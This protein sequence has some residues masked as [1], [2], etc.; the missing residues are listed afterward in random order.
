MVLKC[1]TTNFFVTKILKDIIFS[2]LWKQIFVMIRVGMSVTKS[3]YRY[4]L[5]SNLLLFLIQIETR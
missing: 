3:S 1:A 5:M 4:S 2:T